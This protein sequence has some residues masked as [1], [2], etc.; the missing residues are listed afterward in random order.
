MLSTF[1]EWIGSG[2]EGQVDLLAAGMDPGALALRAYNLLIRA[3]IGCGS[4]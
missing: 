1:S 2:L 3:L 4:L